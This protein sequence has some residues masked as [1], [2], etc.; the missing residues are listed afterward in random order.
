MSGRGRKRGGRKQRKK[1]KRT[2]F[3]GREK[4]KQ[5]IALTSPFNIFSESFHPRVKAVSFS[6]QFLQ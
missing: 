5:T 4:N 3:R 2:R 1:K 6:S